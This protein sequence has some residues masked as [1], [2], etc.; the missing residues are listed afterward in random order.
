MNSTHRVNI[1]RI[2]AILPH[3]NADTL[4][5]VYIGSYQC[6]IKKDAYKVGDLA[7]YIQPDT[8]APVI[9]AFAFLWADREF[10]NDTVP[11]R[12]RRCLLY[13]S[14]CV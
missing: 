1:V 10:D 12:Y 4:G 14:R 2:D 8:L 11:E 6:V 13:T 9:P 5:I 7:L 3:T